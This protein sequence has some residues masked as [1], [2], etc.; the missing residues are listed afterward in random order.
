MPVYD[1]P[2]KQFQDGNKLFCFPFPLHVS[3]DALYWFLSFK[4]NIWKE[5]HKKNKTEETSILPL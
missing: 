3:H 4:D 2:S 5:Q 1:T